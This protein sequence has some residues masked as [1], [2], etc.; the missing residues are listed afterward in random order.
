MGL[1]MDVLT[2]EIPR[3]PF[4]LRTL[5]G[6]LRRQ[7]PILK[8]GRLT[9]LVTGEEQ[10]REVFS[11]PTE[12]LFGFGH[13]PK[14]KLG[15]FLFGMDAS[16]QYFAEK[17]ALHAVTVQKAGD[18][19]RFGKLV[20]QHANARL[21]A[22]P[23]KKTR[24]D[25]LSEFIEPVLLGATADFYGLDLNRAKS[26]YVD[27]PQGAET[28]AQW[29]RKLGGAVGSSWPAPF[30]LEELSDRVAPEMAH[31]IEEQV[32]DAP[33]DSVIWAL[34]GLRDSPLKTPWDIARCVGG[35]MLAGAAVIKASTLALQE[36]LVRGD[37]RRKV[38]SEATK[39]AKGEV[40]KYAWEALRFRPAFPILP[41]YCPRAT[42]LAAGTAY[43]TAVPAGATLLISPL[44]AMFDP[45]HVERPEEFVPTRPSDTYYIFGFGLHRCLGERLGAEAMA[46]LLTCLLAN[47]D[48]EAGH[49]GYEGPA[50]AQYVVTSQLLRMQSEVDNAAMRSD[51]PRSPSG[52]HRAA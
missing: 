11:R 49:I 32:V 15:P 9:L 48:L 13:G 27:A 4:F 3:R 24:I 51:D 14:M 25:L 23:R 38:V 22:L 5:V 45:R 26:S 17:A 19:A 37:V 8:A 44:G 28:Y 34:N 6:L 52:Q 41:R 2:L 50:I 31:F 20:S 18:I 21:A 39:G 30:G 47:V 10:V 35:L 36:L 29:V 12:F 43:E 7:S 46:E 42:T 40:L 33:R 16:E 1:L